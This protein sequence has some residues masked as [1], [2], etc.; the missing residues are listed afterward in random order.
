M[1]CAEIQVSREL[2][3]GRGALLTCHI[4]VNE[5][6]APALLSTLIPYHDTALFGRMLQTLELK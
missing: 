5:F 2:Y 6:N 1:A 4:R 3:S